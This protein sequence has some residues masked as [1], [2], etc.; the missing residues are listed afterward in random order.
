MFNGVL[1]DLAEKPY[2]PQKIL[3]QW[4][5]CKCHAGCYRHSYFWPQRSWRPLEAKNT[6]QRPKMTWRSSFIEK[7]IKSCSIT[8][9]TPWWLQSDLSYDFTE[10]TSGTKD[11]SQQPPRSLYSSKKPQGYVTAAGKTFWILVQD[12]RSWFLGF[13]NQITIFPRIVSS[14]EYFP[15]LNSFRS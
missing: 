11:T 5:C 15:P 6:P 2:I 4:I 3:L 8:S 7:N 1:F 14:L 12:Q 13:Y 10:V 9:K